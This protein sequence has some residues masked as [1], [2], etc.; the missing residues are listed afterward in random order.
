LKAYQADIAKFS[1]AGAQV[2]GISVDAREKNRRFAQELG[3]KFPI[4]SDEQKT[5]SKEYRVLIPLVRLANR[6]TFV[7]GK[8]G[9]IQHIDTGG[10][11]VD[12]T[13][14]LQICS[15]PGHK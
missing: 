12:P 4:L 14:A 15:L 1:Q 10:G 6:T 5:V 9:L 7:I 8:D 13:S 3:I 11:A 2:I